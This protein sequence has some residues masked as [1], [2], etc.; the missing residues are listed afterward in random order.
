MILAFLVSVLYWPGIMGAPSAP[1]WAL[2]SVAVPALL[3]GVRVRF[4]AVHLMGAL[5][6]LWCA[7]SLLWTPDVYDGLHALWKFLVLA[8]LF[9][10]AVE[11]E[12]LRPVFMG[13]GLG[14]AVNSVLMVMQALG[15]DQIVGLGIIHQKSIPGGLF[16]NG[17]FAAEFAAMTLIGLIGFKLW[18]LVPF[19]VVGIMFTSARGA[20]VA[21]AAAFLGWLWTKSRLASVALALDCAAL[22]WFMLSCSGHCVG[23]GNTGPQR[24]MVWNDTLGLITWHGQGIG[25]YLMSYP[26]HRFVF[27]HA[28]ND[29]LQIAAET[30]IGVLLFAAFLA[31]VAMG[32]G[33][34]ERLILLA[35]MVIGLVGY[36]LYIPGTAF[37]AALVAGRLCRSWPDLRHSLSDWRARIHAC[38]YRAEGK[39]LLPSVP[40]GRNLPA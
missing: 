34:T 35:F 19:P 6:L 2:L 7:L 36:P 21:L 31:M 39:P 25:S 28:H 16:G 23:H 10:W 14:V 12:D 5:F 9:C 37:V 18:W 26:Q 29:L 11:Q 32:S 8:G 22:G 27:E 4:T 24:L 15:L 17:N 40:S 20:V 3:W 33:L 13:L 38:Q 1:R 30:G